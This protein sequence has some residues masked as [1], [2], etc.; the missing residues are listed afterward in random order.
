MN[1]QE[2]IKWLREAEILDLASGN[3]K[4]REAVNMAISAL[5][6]QSAHTNTPNALETLDCVERQKA[7]EAV[8]HITSSMSVCVNTDE[9]HGMKRMQRQAVI[10]LANLPSA[11]PEPQWIPVAER[12]PEEGQSILVTADGWRMVAIIRTFFKVMHKD[13]IAWMPLPEPYRAERRTD[14]GD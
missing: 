6:A 11:Q 3:T 9:C 8:E 10:E 12:L 14:E 4:D 13:I 1:N 5:K 7:I 2:A